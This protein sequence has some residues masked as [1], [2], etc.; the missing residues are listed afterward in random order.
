MIINKGLP[1]KYKTS[2]V[3]LF[4]N[5]LGEKF[6]PILREKSKA[7]KLLELSLNQ[8]NCFSAEDEGKLLGVLAYQ[9]KENAFLLPSLKNIISI[10]GFLPLVPE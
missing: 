6:M 7:K 5:A 8:N 1:T 4:I 2:V 3:E 9:T 10:Y